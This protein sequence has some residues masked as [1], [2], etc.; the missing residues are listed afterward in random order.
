MVLSR[1]V[2]VSQ[3][4]FDPAR[5][6]VISQLGSLM[7]VSRRNNE[8]AGITGALAYDDAWFFQ[9]L[10]GARSAIWQTFGRINE[11]DRHTGCL[12]VEMVDVHERTFGNW[13]MGLATR[14][15]VSAP[16]FE[17]FL[18]KGVLRADLMSARDVLSLM[19]ALAKL[20]LNRDMRSAA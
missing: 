11:D 19:T 13:W 5:G 18:D 10:E 8:A 14:D 15:A 16:A 2:Y 12:L 7:A 6:S 3:P 17:P 9:V 20:G 1:L 4:C